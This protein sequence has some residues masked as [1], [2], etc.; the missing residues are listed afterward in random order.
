MTLIGF[1]VSSTLNQLVD[2][3]HRATVLSFKGVAFNLAYAGISL[4][5]ALALHH[6]HGADPSAILAKAFALLPLWLILVWSLLL[7]AFHQHRRII[8]QKLTA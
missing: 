3:H 8:M 5:F 7:I 1:T 2:S 4:L 6:F